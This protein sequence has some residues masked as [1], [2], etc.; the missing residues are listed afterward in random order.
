[1]FGAR[2]E[3]AK[4]I[5]GVFQDPVRAGEIVALLVLL[6]DTFNL[7]VLKFDWSETSEDRN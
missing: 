3:E 1:M 2:I 6:H 7:P 4:E 5:R